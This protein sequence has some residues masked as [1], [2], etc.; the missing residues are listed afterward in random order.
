MTNY[1]AV[2]GQIIYL[3]YLIAVLVLMIWLVKSHLRWCEKLTPAEREEIAK[4]GD[5]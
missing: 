5:W 4:N 3:L 1:T 2:E